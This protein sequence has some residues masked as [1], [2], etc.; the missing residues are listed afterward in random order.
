MAAANVNV[1]EDVWD[2][3]HLQLRDTE[4]LVRKAG[5]VRRMEEK[6]RGE[7]EHRGREIGQS[8][9]E[10]RSSVHAC[11]PASWVGLR[12]GITGGG[13]MRELLRVK[14]QTADLAWSMIG[15]E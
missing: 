13:W 3:F 14:F 9:P 5:V 12:R 7:Y 4:F 10:F 2:A 8:Q 1:D 6:M 15:R 11:P